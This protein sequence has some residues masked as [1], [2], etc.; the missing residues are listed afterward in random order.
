MKT[1]IKDI[2]GIEIC[3]GDKVTRVNRLD[4]STVWTVKFGPY[5]T[6]IGNTFK[7][8][9]ALTLVDNEGYE[10]EMETKIHWQYDKDDTTEY[11][12]IKD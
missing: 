3:V 7:V 6:L 1:G 9:H 2:N 10:Q 5:M 11:K 4:S 8:I 12:I